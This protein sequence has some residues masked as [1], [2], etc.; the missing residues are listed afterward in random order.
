MSMCDRKAARQGVARAPA[1]DQ[2]MQAVLAVEFIILQGVDDV[3]TDEPEDDGDGQQ[4][5]Q[6]G[7]YSRA[8]DV[9]GRTGMKSP[10]TASHAPIGASAS[11]RPRKTWVKSVNRLVRE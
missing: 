2:R 5:R 7:A 3:E 4:H 8:A 6:Q 1:H 9:T 10:L 11:A